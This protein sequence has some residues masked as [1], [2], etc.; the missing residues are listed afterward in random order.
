MF[1]YLFFISF[2]S[3]VVSFIVCAYLQFSLVPL[4][5]LAINIILSF[6]IWKLTTLDGIV[7]NNQKDNI[8]SIKQL[9]KEISDLKEQL[10]ELKKNQKDE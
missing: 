6:T 10:E 4:I 9:K 8:K 2:I 7:N 3:V 5:A 1:L